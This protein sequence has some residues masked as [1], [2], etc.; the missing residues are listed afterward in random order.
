M[1]PV[2]IIPLASGL[3]TFNKITIPEDFNM[4]DSMLSALIK[5]ATGHLVAL[6]VIFGTPRR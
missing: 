3:T 1:F 2:E 6:F 5:T 4:D